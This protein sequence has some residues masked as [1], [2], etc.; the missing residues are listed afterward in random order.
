MNERG[1]TIVEV[2]IAIIVLTVGLLGLMGTSALVTRMVARGQRSALAGIHA[3]ERF[4]QLRA[5]A[6]KARAAGSE[7]FYRGGVAVARNEW[8]WS[9][10]GTDMFRLS[11]KTTYVTTQ[12]RQRADSTEA[13]ISCVR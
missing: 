8:T 13:T 3:S 9:T 5:T 7:T 12:G 10:A 1:F 4:E 2:L 6:C 11:L